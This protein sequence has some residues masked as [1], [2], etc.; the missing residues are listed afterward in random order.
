MKPIL[1]ADRFSSIAGASYGATALSRMTATPTEEGEDG[2]TGLLCWLLVT[3]AL[4]RNDEP[5]S[6]WM[7]LNDEIDLFGLTFP[8]LAA[9]LRNRMRGH[10]TSCVPILLLKPRE[11]VPEFWKSFCAYFPAADPQ[12]ESLRKLLFHLIDRYERNLFVPGDWKADLRDEDRYSSPDR[13]AIVKLRLTLK[14][15]ISEHEPDEEL[16]PRWRES[17]AKHKI[18]EALPARIRRGFAPESPVFEDLVLAILQVA[19]WL[20]RPDYGRIEASLQ[21]MERRPQEAFTEDQRIFAGAFLGWARGYQSVA[22]WVQDQEQRR[23]LSEQATALSIVSEDIK[24]C[25]YIGCDPRIFHLSISGSRSAVLNR[26][27]KLVQ[28]SHEETRLITSAAEQPKV[29]SRDVVQCQAGTAF[30][31]SYSF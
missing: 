26:Y 2:G 15:L 18:L 12:R 20:S 6:T 29:R 19:E 23:A 11:E 7:W 10:W 13:C 4:A 24:D 8:P 1:L 16:L 14:A 28:C 5:Q 31:F 25:S 3:E 27:L 17:V 30:R 9:E 21:D 22:A